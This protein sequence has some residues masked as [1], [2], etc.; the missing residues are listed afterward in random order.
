MLSANHLLLST[1]KVYWPKHSDIDKYLKVECTPIMNGVE[2]PSVFAV[3]SLV[4]PGISID[5]SC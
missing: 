5:I 2:Y 3:S 1:N 4:S